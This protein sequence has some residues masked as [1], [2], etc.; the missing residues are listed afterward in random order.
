MMKIRRMSSIYSGWLFIALGLF[1]SFTISESGCDF[2]MAGLPATTHLSISIS[3]P[4]ATVT[5]SGKVQ[6]TATVTHYQHD[7]TVTWAIVGSVG[8]LGSDGSTATFTAPQSIAFSPM[9]VTIRVRSNEDTTRFA[10]CIV[11]VQSSTAGHAKVAIV[12]N[13]TAI[14]LQAGKTQQFTAV[15]SGSPDSMVFWRVVSGLG[16]LSASGLFTAPT[17]IGSSPKTTVIQATPRADTL[18]HQQ[19]VIQLVDPADTFVCFQSMIFPIVI[20]NCAM[21][22]CHSN[23]GRDPN[24]TSF[25][26][27]QSVVTPGNTNDSK[28]Y[29]TISSN[30]EE[31]MPPIPRG[32]LTAAQIALIARWINQGAQ[33]T[34]CIDTTAACDTVG[35]SYSAFIGGVMRTYCVGCHTGANAGSGFDLTT[36]S[37]VKTVVANGRLMGSIEQR[38]GYFA[39]PQSSPKLD[40]CTLAKIGAWVN[41]GAPSN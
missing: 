27:I 22:G 26:G 29:T 8:Q 14:T 25:D 4:E 30:G 17:S 11:T 24:L 33:N 3:P 15:V 31:R 9:L 10:E 7:S 40:A 18:K 1:L 38:Y 20:S 23:G 21:S 13:P 37:G 2:R 16:T 41:A 19:A 32:A 36:Y 5:T 12:L 28:L 6:M 39:M 35:V 34:S